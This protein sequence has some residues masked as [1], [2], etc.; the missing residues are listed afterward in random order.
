MHIV[1]LSVVAN[2]HT[3]DNPSIYTAHPTSTHKTLEAALETAEQNAKTNCEG[4]KT[5]IKGEYAQEMV[6]G[7]TPGWRTEHHDCDYWHWV[8]S[9]S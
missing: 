7:T 1:M 9:L 6:E 2:T 4:T 8:C 5:P 3:G